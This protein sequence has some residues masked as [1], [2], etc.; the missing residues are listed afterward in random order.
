M[1]K[2]GTL[3]VVADM[4]RTFFRRYLQIAQWNLPCGML[5]VSPPDRSVNFCMPGL[6][7]E[8]V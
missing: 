7:P 5:T 6:V 8:C 2:G 1:R 4:Q 3:T